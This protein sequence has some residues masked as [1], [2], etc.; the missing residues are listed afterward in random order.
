MCLAPELRNQIYNILIDDIP[1]TAFPGCLREC[2][3]LASTNKIIRREFLTLL[4]SRRSVTIW[5]ICSLSA[6]NVFL[7]SLHNG[8]AMI[9]Q[10]NLPDFAELAS[11]RPRAEEVM[12]FLNGLPNLTELKIVFR[13]D[14]IQLPQVA[15]HHQKADGCR[16]RQRA[17]VHNNR[18]KNPEVL[19]F[20]TLVEQFAHDHALFRLDGL[21]RV[22]KITVT[23]EPG[24]IHISNVPYHHR[25]LAIFAGVIPLM[26][27]MF[28][29]ASPPIRVTERSVNWS[30]DVTGLAGVRFFFRQRS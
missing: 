30:R 19:K 3:A 28:V 13:L 14:H 10:V 2:P 18:E 24:D 15:S 26:E 16:S 1:E 21:R 9:S 20:R 4:L 7:Q 6:F 12:D 29:M 22:K 25:K 5:S 11:S 17:I 27:R 8:H 23:C